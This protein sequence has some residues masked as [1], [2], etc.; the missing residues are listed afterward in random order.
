MNEEL[1]EKLKLVLKDHGIDEETTVD[2][3]AELDAEP[4]GEGEEEAV[5][6]IQQEGVETTAP[7]EE[8]TTEEAEV[9]PAEGQVAEPPAPQPEEGQLPPPT[10]P[11]PGF[12]LAA[13]DMK[14]EELQKANEGL[15]SRI[16]SLEDALR[17][18]G[19]I[20]GEGNKGFGFAKEYAPDKDP[21]DDG[22]ESFLMRAN[23]KSY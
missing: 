3:L 6:P 16:E 23:R 15:I 5:D 19:V 7:E 14:I 9:P 11:Q 17:K 2:V 20:E 10:E 12:D 21:A 22:L 13:Y 8:T 1:K 18:A 4:K